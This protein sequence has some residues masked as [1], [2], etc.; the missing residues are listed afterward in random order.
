MTGLRKSQASLH[1]RVGFA[2]SNCYEVMLLP[3]HPVLSY[4]L[5]AFKWYIYWFED[6]QSGPFIT[7]T[8]YL[9]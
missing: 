6:E 9:V 8:M 2:L 7:C 5:K 4:T 1:Y 3:L